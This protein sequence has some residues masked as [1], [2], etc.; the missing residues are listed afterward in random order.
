MLCSFSLPA[1]QGAY[2]SKEGH[3]PTDEAG[4]VSIK[5][6]STRRAAVPGALDS[7]SRTPLPSAPCAGGFVDRQRMDTAWIVLHASQR[8]GF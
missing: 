7:L 8:T 2:A 3:P 5:Y 1:Q 4:W 6:G